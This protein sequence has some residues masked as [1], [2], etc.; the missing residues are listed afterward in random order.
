MGRKDQT[1]VVQF[2]KWLFM[3]DFLVNFSGIND[4][5][6]LGLSTTDFSPILFTPG[7]IILIVYLG[8]Y[9]ATYSMSNL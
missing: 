4:I 9:R 8:H 6:L 7:K 1:L 5:V 3:A 2:G